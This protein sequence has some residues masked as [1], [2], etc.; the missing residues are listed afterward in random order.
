MRTTERVGKLERL[1][2]LVALLLALG[3]LAPWTHG[4]A[5]A[6]DDDDD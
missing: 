6:D 2:A 4:P 5:L 3:P 1:A